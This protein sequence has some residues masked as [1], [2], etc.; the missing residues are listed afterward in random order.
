MPSGGHARSGPRPDPNSGR[1]ARRGFT[2]IPLP[3]RHDG[4]APRYP[5]M[6]YAVIETVSADGGRYERRDDA[7]TAAFRERERELWEWAWTLPQASRWAAET[8]RIQAVA[9][10][11]RTSV[12]CESSQATAADRGSLHR[13]ADQIG[14]TPAGLKE[15]GWCIPA[16]VEDELKP[17]APR[18]VSSR[19]R[20]EVIDGVGA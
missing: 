6:P 3:E 14:M 12:L 17:A 15:N 2:L 19:S 20:F 11:V 10:W 1:S 5:L 4:P 18:T 8:W 16:S 7:A 13:F 9:Q